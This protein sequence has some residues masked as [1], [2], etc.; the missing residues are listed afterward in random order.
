MP[1]PPGMNST[2][3]NPTPH[4]EETARP[5]AGPFFC[6]LTSSPRQLA[7]AAA[8]HFDLTARPRALTSS[9]PAAGPAARMRRTHAAPPVSL[10]AAVENRVAP[11]YPGNRIS[12][13]TV[14]LRRSH[15]QHWHHAPG[16][17]ATAR[18]AAQIARVPG[19]SGQIAMIDRSW[20][21]AQIDGPR[22][23]GPRARAMFRT[24]NYKKFDM[25]LKNVFLM[26]NIPYRFT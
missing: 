4:L 3:S 21:R 24:N 15:V 19:I 18:Q 12:A 9:F 13:H 25:T 26:L 10:C 5:I 8:H 6:A 2:S 14:A 22:P 17:C 16:A 20:R 11:R 7:R 23:G 1:T